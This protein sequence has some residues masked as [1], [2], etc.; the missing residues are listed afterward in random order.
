MNL[1]RKSAKK[2][3]QNRGFEKQPCAHEWEHDVKVPFGPGWMYGKRC[4]KCGKTQPY[5]I[6]V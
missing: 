6:Q 2:K 3:R 5:E 1:I 4:K